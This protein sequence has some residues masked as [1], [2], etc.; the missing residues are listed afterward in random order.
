[1]YE[2]GTNSVSCG[3]MHRLKFGLFEVRGGRD[4]KMQVARISRSSVLV[5]RDSFLRRR[6]GIL[7]TM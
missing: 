3:T 2:P 5:V 6:L 7:H 1:M 4:R